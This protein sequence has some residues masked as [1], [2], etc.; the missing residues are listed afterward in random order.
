MNKERLIGK[1][2]ATAARLWPDVDGT[3]AGPCLYRAGSLAYVLH[4]EAP[5]RAILQAGT[6]LWPRLTKEQDDGAESTHTHFGYEWGGS[7]E[8]AINLTLPAGHV[9]L[10]EMHVWVAH[11]M[12]NRDWSIIDVCSGL[13]PHLAKL[14]GMDWPGKRPPTHLWCKSGALPEGVIYRANTQA[15]LLAGAL[16]RQAAAHAAGVNP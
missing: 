9:S 10:P 13:F 2:L 3:H 6:C 16:F 4:K 7:P 8:G 15:C 11:T 5:G 12:N 1:A 14:S